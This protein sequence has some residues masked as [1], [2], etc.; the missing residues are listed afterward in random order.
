MIKLK[1]LVSASSGYSPSHQFT[2]KFTF[3]W[4]SKLVYDESS[5]LVHYPGQTLSYMNNNKTPKIIIKKDVK[6]YDGD[7]YPKGFAFIGQTYELKQVFKNISNNKYDARM[8]FYF[9]K[10]VPKTSGSSKFNFW[11]T[12]S[13]ESAKEAIDAINHIFG[14]QIIKM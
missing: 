13:G 2:G 11:W 7:N 5:P 8:K 14:R 4:P 6:F 10:S 9:H 3:G 1:E 12:E